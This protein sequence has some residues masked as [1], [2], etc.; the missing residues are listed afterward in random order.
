M[1]ALDSFARAI[2]ALHAEGVNWLA[3]ANAQAGPPT[4]GVAVHQGVLLCLGMGSRFA[5]QTYYEM[6]GGEHPFD[7]RAVSLV[8]PLLGSHLRR[9]DPEARLVYPGT[10]DSINLLAWLAAAKAQY[11]SRLGIGIRPDCGTWFAVRAALV[12]HL[13]P[14]VQRWLEGRY[15]SL[16]DESSPCD[17]C[18]ERPC[19]PAC[20]ATAVASTFQLDRCARQRLTAQ[21]P[22]A[23]TCAARLACPV[24]ST[25]R[26][27]KPQIAYHYSVS[28][29]MLKRWLDG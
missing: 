9:W 3:Y 20:P 16:R 27:S 11:P 25:H 1:L 26:Y 15:P 2:D 12:T 24:G 19:Q 21:S 8:A 28:L 4:P 18:S 23:A 7:E 10:K 22:C 5:E 6:G 14:E 13:P 17:S 29:R